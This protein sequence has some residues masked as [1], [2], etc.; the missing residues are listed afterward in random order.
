MSV[1]MNP[2]A[3]ALT[4]TFAAG[5]LHRQGPREG[6]DRPLAGR[7]VRLAGVHVLGRHA[8]DIDD[9]PVRCF[10]MR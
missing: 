1:S 8:R 3:M 6:V 9:P 10:I 5:Q 4:V 2:G 7:V